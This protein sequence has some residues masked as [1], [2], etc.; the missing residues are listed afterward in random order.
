M[1]RRAL[2]H[3]HLRGCPLGPTTLGQGL[4]AVARALK[5]VLASQL[6]GMPVFCG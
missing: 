4:A 1:Q 2:A 6:N 3:H 5:A